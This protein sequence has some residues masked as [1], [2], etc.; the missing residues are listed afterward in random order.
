MYVMT[1]SAAHL[2]VRDMTVPEELQLSLCLVFI[3]S[4]GQHLLL[5]LHDRLCFLGCA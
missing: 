5:L 3:V 1:L 4:L 2:G